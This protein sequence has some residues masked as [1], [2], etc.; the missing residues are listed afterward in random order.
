MARS[1]RHEAEFNP[2]PAFVDVFSSIILVLLLFI[3]ISIVNIAYYMQFNSTVDS[4]TEVKKDV[5]QSQNQDPSK[6]VNLKKSVIQVDSQTSQQS[7]FKGGESEGN[8]ISSKKDDKEYKQNIIS[9][10][11]QLIIAY[12]NKEVFVTANSK[13]KIRSFISK[14]R[15]KKLILEV[16][17][18]MNIISSTLK[19]QISIGRLITI[20]N[21]IQKS[22]ISLDNISID[23]KNIKDPKYPYGY[24][25]ILSL[26]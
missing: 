21:I 8:S 3:L 14:N 13:R 4:T 2:W 24:V 7:M 9:Q 25:K 22:G 5:D 18:S 26:N 1:R 15:D 20:K 16:A 12:S 17:N 23:I 6:M 11:N 19:K 10:A